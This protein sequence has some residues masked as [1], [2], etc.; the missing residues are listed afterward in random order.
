MREG[1]GSFND[2][3]SNISGRYGA[4]EA[5]RVREAMTALASRDAETLQ[6]EGGHPPGAGYRARM[7]AANLTR[8]AL[9]AAPDAEFVNGIEI[10]LEMVA[11]EFAEP[12]TARGSEVR[13]DL[14]I[15]IDDLF[16]KRGVPYSYDDGA[17]VW[18]GDPGVRQVVIE[19]V[20]QALSDVRL[21]GAA[22]EFE[23]ALHH[24]RAG[25]QK[26]LEDAIEEAAKSVESALKVLAAETNTT[27]SATATAKPLFDAVKD[28]GVVSPYMDNLVQAAARIRNKLGGHGAGAQPRQIETH[29]AT[30]TVN[31]AAVAIAFLAS[32]LP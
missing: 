22:S 20:L 15:Q 2:F 19:P 8:Y 24:L 14:A 25:T 5:E 3:V 9:I 12:G 4:D 32:R 1:C 11:A 28:A 18:A 21:A 23:A 31:A 6:L 26:D 30:A 17:F 10:A 27:V 7:M 13:H 29:E 16:A